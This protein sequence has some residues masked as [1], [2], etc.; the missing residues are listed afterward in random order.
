MKKPAVLLALLILLGCSSTKVQ[1]IGPKRPPRPKD[2]PIAVHVSGDA[3]ES[4]IREVNANIGRP[5]GTAIGRLTVQTSNFRSWSASVKEA[6]KYAR[7]LGGD[8]I[9]VTGFE[10]YARDTAA[11]RSDLFVTVFRWDD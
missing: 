6:S 10:N 8:A 5:D 4:V 9:Y 2:W 7:E 11:L 1:R 3:P